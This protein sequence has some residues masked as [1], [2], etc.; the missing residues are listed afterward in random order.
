MVNLNI[1]KPQDKPFLVALVISSISLKQTLVSL[2]ADLENISLQ[3][4]C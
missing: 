4:Q 2:F 1:N 3:I